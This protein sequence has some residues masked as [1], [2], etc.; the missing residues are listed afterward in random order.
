VIWLVLALHSTFL[1]LAL[2]A[3]LIALLAILAACTFCLALLAPFARR[4]TELLVARLSAVALLAELIALLA[5]LAAC[6]F[7]LA[8]LAPFARR[9]TELL[10]A[11]LSA[12]ARLA[13]LIAFLAGAATVETLHTFSLA[14]L[15]LFA[16]VTWLLLACHSTFAWFADPALQASRSSTIVTELGRRSIRE[17]KRA[18]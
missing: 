18:A 10:V 11:R 4:V 7:C 12:V 14:L 16:Q 17:G 8:L 1:I 6:T 2:L 3:E 9:V 13:E 15:T 5:I